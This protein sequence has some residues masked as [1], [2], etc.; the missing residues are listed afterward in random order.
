[1]RPSTMR[2]QADAAVAVAGWVF[3]LLV[4]AAD[5][6]VVLNSKEGDKVVLQP[7][8]PVT[9]TDKEILWKHNNDLAMESDVSGTTGY[10]QFKAPVP[11]PTILK[12]CDVAGYSCVLTCD[13]N[14]TDAEPVTY[15]WKSGDRVLTDKTKEKVLTMEN[16]SDM[17]EFSCELVNPVSRESSQAITNPLIIGE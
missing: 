12:T 17:D 1:M 6:E 8:I 11:K 15:E 10:R 14:T 16:S 4:A 13:G 2:A 5:S 7:N 3:V 9:S